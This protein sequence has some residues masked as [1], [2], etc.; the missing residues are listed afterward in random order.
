[1]TKRMIEQTQRKMYFSPAH[2]AAFGSAIQL[3]RSARKQIKKL[4]LK[5]VTNF[6]ER[7]TAY[8]MHRP[9]KQHFKRRK[10]YA[11]YVDH[12]WQMDLVSLQ[13]IAKENSGYN[14]IFTVIDVLSRYA[15]AEPLKRKTGKKVMG[16]FKRL[17]RKYK[18]KPVKVKMDQ[19]QE[20]YNEEFKTFLHE[21]NIA[22][23]STSSDMKCA[24]AER[25]NR[26][27]KEK[28]FKYFTHHNT[29]RYITILPQLI[30][31]YNNRP[32]VSLD[33]LKPANVNRN[34]QALV[35]RIHYD[36]DNEYNVKKQYIKSE[37][38]CE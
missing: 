11:R 15:F 14:C 30:D 13:A 26:T 12:I 9:V 24:L 8:T 16:A 3:H 37:T 21:N 18:R 2:P 5:D 1:M 10:P 28:M 27:L 22:H 19:G 36:H 34:N 4:T 23:Y 17:L 35:R 33:G 38:M 29:L 31:A 20:F 7:Q 32:H 6:L 25:F